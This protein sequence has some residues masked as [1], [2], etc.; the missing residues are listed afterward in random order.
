MVRF[1][2]LLK[3]V[4]YVPTKDEKRGTSLNPYHSHFILVD[5]TANEVYSRA[6]QFILTYINNQ[7]KQGYKKYGHDVQYIFLFIDDLE[8]NNTIRFRSLLEQYLCRKWE[9]PLLVVVVGGG[10]VTLDTIQEALTNAVPL[11]IVK[12]TGG[13]ADFVAYP[14]FIY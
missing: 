14:K 2:I 4:D 7:D 3:S 10:G 11:V 9:I 12:G 1:I 8:I 13:V 5:G 6:S